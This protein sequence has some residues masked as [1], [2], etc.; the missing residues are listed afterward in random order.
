MATAQVM[1]GCGRA[2]HS[3]EISPDKE[4]YLAV[5]E[6]KQQFNCPLC[7]LNDEINESCR[8]FLLLSSFFPS[9]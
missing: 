8:S 6:H 5:I 4:K 7:L 9:S 1:L 2:R 3:F